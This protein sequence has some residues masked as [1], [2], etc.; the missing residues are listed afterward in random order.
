LDPVSARIV[1]RTR[2]GHRY[3]LPMTDRPLVIGRSRECDL[4]LED[5]FV[6]RRHARVEQRKGKFIIVDEGSRNGTVVRGQQINSQHELR[7]EDEI[8]IGDTALL[9]LVGSPEDSTTQRLEPLSESQ[10]GSPVQVDPQSWEVWVEGKKLE[11]KLSVLEFKLLAH[12]YRNAGI[13]CSRDEIGVELWG[14]GAYTFEML[15]Q[16]VHRL[17]RRIEPDPNNPR[18]LVSLPGVGYR[19]EGRAR[20]R[21]VS[22]S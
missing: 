21:D 20:K 15:H 2:G 17:K 6:S 10:I 22:A 16:L 9:F 5:D 13:V 11:Q 19:L 12:L 14:E 8:R 4:I 7:H 18:F 1:V 3:E